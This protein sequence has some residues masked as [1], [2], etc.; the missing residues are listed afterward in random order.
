MV[1]PAAR[2]FLL[3]LQYEGTRYCGWQNQRETNTVQAIIE[4]ALKPLALDAALLGL[5]AV[6]MLA[7]ANAKFRKRLA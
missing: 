4:Q 7:L 1:A 6:A 5:F 2:R 3:I